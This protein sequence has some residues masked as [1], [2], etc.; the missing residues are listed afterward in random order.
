MALCI[1]CKSDCEDS[2]STG[3]LFGIYMSA[4]FNDY[5]I[6][7]CNAR[8]LFDKVVDD[9][10]VR[11][12]ALGHTYELEVKK[13]LSKTRIGG[14]G[15]RQFISENGITGW[16]LLCFSLKGD[17]PK[18]SVLYVGGGGEEGSFKSTIVAQRSNLTEEEE[19]R[20]LDIVPPANSFIGV[21]FVTRLTHSNIVNNNMK[22]PKKMLS[23]IGSFYDQGLAE[24]RLRADPVS[25]VTYKKEN[26]G[27][28]SF[29][30]EA[31]RAFHMDEPDLQISR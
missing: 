3:L 20:L 2:L 5:V 9:S 13:G 11:F 16:E 22:L 18:I 7:P 31:W 8:L 14:D 19:D 12:K 1:V 17:T 25:T 4:H 29:N 27:R 21:P 10:V 15:W 26:D 28:I 24:V 23:F 30:R 6:V